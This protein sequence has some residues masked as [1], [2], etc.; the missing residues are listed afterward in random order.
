MKGR[1]TGTGPPNGVGV[2]VRGR[3]VNVLVTLR[4]AVGV[5]EG[6]RVMLLTQFVYPGVPLITPPTASLAPES[7]PTNVAHEATPS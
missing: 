6:V 2:A 7:V 4:V 5:R 1:P 3:G